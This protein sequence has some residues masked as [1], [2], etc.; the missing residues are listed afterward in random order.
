M[1][2]IIL[3]ILLFCFG[4]CI[5][6]A[7]EVFGTDNEIAKT[8][9][10]VPFEK[11]FDKLFDN[12]GK[13]KLLTRYTF[14]INP[15]KWERMSYHKKVELYEACTNYH[16]AKE[17]SLGNNVLREISKRQVR[18][19]SSVDGTLLV[20]YNPNSGILFKTGTE[21]F[22]NLAKNL[23]FTSGVDTHQPKT[24]FKAIKAYT[25]LIDSIIA[26]NNYSYK[27][28]SVSR[29]YEVTIDKYGSIKKIELLY[30]NYIPCVDDY[31]IDTIRTL[32]PFPA[33][34]KYMQ[35]D[36]ISIHVSLL[37]DLKDVEGFIKH[38]LEHEQEYQQKDIA[39]VNVKTQELF[40]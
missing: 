21:A 14:F 31:A 11:K 27:K 16:L 36:E 4:F 13:N 26:D 30:Y 10:I 5:A 37:V 3:A 1:H 17:Y 18:I 35:L 6:E 29:S 34:N 28:L 24:Q 8:I 2:K 32:A 15:K 22:K 9:E 19:R 38:L 12:Y 20:E 23:D 7:K 25:K 33:F 39:K 40:Y